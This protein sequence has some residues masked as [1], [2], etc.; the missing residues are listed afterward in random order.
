M[1]WLFN[2]FQLFLLYRVWK[3][4]RCECFV[5]LRECSWDVCRGNACQVMEVII[6]QLFFGSSIWRKWS[7]KTKLRAAVLVFSQESVTFHILMMTLFTKCFQAITGCSGV[8]LHFTPC[9]LSDLYCCISVTSWNNVHTLNL[10][11]CYIVEK[12]HL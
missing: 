6:S 2:G 8:C 3:W 10:F 7:V 9:P 11:Q 5:F 12:L 1:L 4:K